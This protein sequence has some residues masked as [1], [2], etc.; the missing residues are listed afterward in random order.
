MKRLIS[1]LLLMGVLS[2][3]ATSAQ[4]ETKKATFDEI[5]GMQ[6][7]ITEQ[8][9]EGA[10]YQQLA[11]SV[12]VDTD[13]LIKVSSEDARNINDL[14][15][16]INENLKGQ[17]NDALTDDVVNYLL[18]EFTSTPYEW[19][20]VNTNILGMD[21]A[22]QRFFADITYRTT[23]D[24][25][26]VVPKSGIPAGSPK[27]VELKQLRYDQYMDVLNT[28]M[29]DAE[30]GAMELS[31]FESRWGTVS[32][33]MDSQREVDLATRTREKANTR[34]GIGKLTY[35]GIVDNLISDASSEMTFRFVF[36][37]GLNLGD[38][39]DL[40]IAS[41]YLKNYALSDGDG[42]IKSLTDKEVKNREIIDPYVDKLILT[43]N[44]A[45]EGGNDIGLYS[46]FSDYG[47][48]DKLYRD[49][50][51]YSYTNHRGYVYDILS[52]R[53]DVYYVKVDGTNQFRGKGFNMSMPTYNETY[54]FSITPVGQ[55]KLGIIGIQRVKSVLV[56]EPL[57]LIKDV[58]GVSNQIAYSES[59]FTSENEEKV[60]RVIN[61]FGILELNNTVRGAD[62]ITTVDTGIS[63]NQM[64]TLVKNIET[65]DATEKVTWVSE[66]VVKSNV[67][68]CAKLHEI[69]LGGKDA[70]CASVIE[71]TN[72]NGDW[73]V[74]SYRKSFSTDYDA[75]VELKDKGSIGHVKRGDK[76]IS[77]KA[78]E[79]KED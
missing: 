31:S 79:V 78:K 13:N 48:Y 23:K 40:K 3:C 60:K 63:Q 47:S 17:V 32:S 72:Y 7:N 27:E 52:R 30:K 39:T 61:N 43:Y 42:L 33:I 6:V 8:E 50:V 4:P 37:Y 12:T 68:V 18:M 2:G 24:R 57:S 34:G 19:E 5:A 54:I 15:S 69:Y 51:T 58:V 16:K 44:R 64:N 36:E 77:D 41:L 67:Y 22:T 14:V 9:K 62:F 75:K 10:I 49:I 25:K 74:L 11:N 21:A 65:T 38:R 70:E 1:T 20:H 35:N 59:N 66:Y 29:R 73:K 28:Q 26:E 46:I 55:D 45:V 76:L 53:G 56:G 71:L